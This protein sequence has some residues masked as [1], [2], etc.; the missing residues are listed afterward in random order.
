M[1]DIVQNF[2]T[3][4]PPIPWYGRKEL[5]RLRSASPPPTVV[6]T[7]RQKKFEIKKNNF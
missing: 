5:L 1:L 7:F 2:E 4:P 3:S 6:L